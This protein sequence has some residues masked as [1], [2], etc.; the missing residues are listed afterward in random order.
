MCPVPIHRPQLLDAM[1][2]ITRFAGI[3]QERIEHA[4]EFVDDFNRMFLLFLKSSLD[5]IERLAI[6]RSKNKI[7]MF[8]VRPAGT[9]NPC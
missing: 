6:P 2:L 7:S 3:S 4:S 1:V 9:D 8:D 5:E